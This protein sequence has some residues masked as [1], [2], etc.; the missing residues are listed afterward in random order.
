MERSALYPHHRNVLF[1]PILY[2][3][4]DKVTEPAA[5][6]DLLDPSA[7]VV[8]EP[9]DSGFRPRPGISLADTIFAMAS[10]HAN[11]SPMD[12][13]IFEVGPLSGHEVDTRLT[14]ANPCGSDRYAVLGGCK[15]LP[16][17]RH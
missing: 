15:H 6:L 10:N 4:V 7:T 2:P 16:I 1:K 9:Q 5:S 14:E 17:H 12:A 11:A 3:A 13:E 8:A